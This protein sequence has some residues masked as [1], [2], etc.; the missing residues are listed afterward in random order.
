MHQRIVEEAVDHSHLFA[1]HID[2]VAVVA[3]V[4]TDHAAVAVA[5]AGHIDLVEVVH[6]KVVGHTDPAAEAVDHTVPAEEVDRTGPAAVAAVG[7]LRRKDSPRVGLQHNLGAYSPGLPEVGIPV[8]AGE[9][10]HQR[11]GT[12]GDHLLEEEVPDRQTHLVLVVRRRLL[13]GSYLRAP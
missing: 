7:H 9:V 6:E 13:T 10:D 1:G 12:V 4:H 3:A 11:L 2:L 5:A 8:P